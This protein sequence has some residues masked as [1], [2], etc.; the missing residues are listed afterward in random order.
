MPRSRGHLQTMRPAYCARPR[1]RPAHALPVRRQTRRVVRMTVSTASSV[2]GMIMVLGAIALVDPGSGHG[3][4]AAVNRAVSGLRDL[5]SGSGSL[6]KQH[7]D[8]GRPARG[9]GTASGDA[10]GHAN[11][12]SPGPGQHRTLLQR[13]LVF[14][15]HGD[16]TIGHLR[17]SS[18]RTW[19]LRWSYYRC[20]A[21][22]QAG[23]FRVAG[24]G[25]DGAA[26]AA[27]SANRRGE[28][29]LHPTG[30]TH[31][32]TVRSL[33]S[34]TVKV[35]GVLRTCSSKSAKSLACSCLPPSLPSPP[36]PPGSGEGHATSRLRCPPGTQP[37][38]LP[39]RRRC[40]C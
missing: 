17:L 32:L 22:R 23:R 11:H 18:T 6:A 26:T 14:H 8:T 20:P 13:V 36:A 12:G 1:H 3:G 15:G 21:S 35:V 33:C 27:R 38:P 16:R 2:I 4:P 29:R 7:G 31:A 10:R 37:E 9:R 19:E 40:I 25:T 24:A 30:R 39:G 34:W 28:T 5:T